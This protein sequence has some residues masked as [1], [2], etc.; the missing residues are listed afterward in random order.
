MA[1]I[2][3]AGFWTDSARADRA[4]L[5]VPAAPL[6][7]ALRA[8]AEPTRLRIVALLTRGERTVS[9]IAQVLAQSQPRV[10]RHIKILADAGV[11]HRLAEGSWVFCRLSDA[12]VTAAVTPMLPADDIVLNAD[13]ER[14]GELQRAHAE[15]SERYFREHAKNWQAIRQCHVSEHDV[16]ALVL[17]AV[18]TGVLGN[19]VDVGTGTGRMLQLLARRATRATGIDRSSAM[20]AAARPAFD[21][22]AFAHVQLRHG[23]MA[24]LP[25]P[26][27]TADLVVMHQVLHFSDAPDRALRE[28]GRI[29]RPGGRALLVDF[30]PHSLESLRE[31]HGHRRLGFHADEVRLWA[32][33]AGLT[34]ARTA[35]LDGTPLTVVLWELHPIASAPSPT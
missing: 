25:L 10:S 20:L 11:V 30:A 31:E 12:S 18:G 5:S 14:L 3:D 34:V 13:L 35:R 22:P 17:D 8:V 19:V 2:A 33:G 4:A 9:E 15:A 23:D 21:D 16:E 32:A 7:E 1:Q 28:I 24:R 27:A 29:L 6:L 26:N